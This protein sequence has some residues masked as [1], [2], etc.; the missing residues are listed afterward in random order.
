MS[1]IEELREADRQMNAAKT[2]FLDYLDQPHDHN[3]PRRRELQNDVDRSIT[4]FW[5][6]LGELGQ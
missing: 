5:R 1:T 4:E 3:D 6:V 2:A